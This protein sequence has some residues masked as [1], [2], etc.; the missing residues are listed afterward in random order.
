[1]L[2]AYDQ[3]IRIRKDDSNEIAKVILK[4]RKKKYEVEGNHI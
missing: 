2:L 3:S 4:A 1:M